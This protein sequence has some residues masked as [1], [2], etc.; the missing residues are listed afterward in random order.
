[1]SRPLA[2]TV[3]WKAIGELVYFDFLDVGENEVASALDIGD[4]NKYVLVV[5]DD[6]SRFLWLVPAKVCT[7]NV[8]WGNWRIG[9]LFMGHREHW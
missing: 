2:A 1:M 8:R 4:G 3:H 5:E 6:L 9:M 7:A